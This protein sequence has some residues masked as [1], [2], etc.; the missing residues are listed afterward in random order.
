MPTESIGGVIA[1]LRKEKGTTQ[2]EL[3][4]YAQVSTQAVSK[5][6]N[7]G[8]PDTELL[9]KIADFF[10]VSVDT[11]FGRTITDYSDVESA[12]AKKIMD[13]PEAERFTVA[14]ELCW[15]MECALAGFWGPNE[16]TIRELQEELGAQRQHSS[17]CRDDGFTLMCLSRRLPYFL[18]APETADKDI[19]YFD[20]A[21]YIA[22]FHDFADKA[23]FDACVMLNRRESGK[24]F[25]SN[26]LTKNLNI[27]QEKAEEVMGTLTKYGLVRASQIEMD[28]ATQEIFTFL[29]NTPFVAMLTFA[30][31][32]IKGPQSYR[33]FHGKRNQPF[34]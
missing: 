2:E 6:E 16:K 5:W 25:T 34:F 3:A 27:S 33:V 23:V 26:L 30:R 11:L 7:G 18:L 32:V 12:F 24:A 28:D 13:A 21:D 29:P 14:F 9:P 15:V 1:R 22:L 4:K 19:A 20:E 8:V 31:E 10:G 17:V